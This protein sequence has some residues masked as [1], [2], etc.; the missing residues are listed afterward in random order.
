MSL[1]TY[2]HAVGIP[3]LHVMPAGALPPNPSELLDSKA[4]NTLL[5]AI[6][7]S[8]IEMVIFDTAPLLGLA[9]ASILASKVDGTVI[10]ADSTRAKRK[11][12]QQTKVLLTQSGARI[13]GCVVNK[14]NFN[15][16]YMPYYY[17]SSE[18]EEQEKASSQNRKSSDS[19]SSSSLIPQSGRKNKA[20]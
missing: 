10:V 13:L 9:D 12:L 8:K 16:R 2:I 15:R 20:K 7:D 4:T 6:M 1:S 14:Q 18:D 17:Y 5:A 11:H 19:I 3:N